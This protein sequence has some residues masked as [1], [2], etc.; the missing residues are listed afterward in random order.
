LLTLPVALGSA[1]LYFT[2]LSSVLYLLAQ[3]QW[4]PFTETYWAFFDYVSIAWSAAVVMLAVVTLTAGALA[5]RGI[6][7]VAG[8]VLLVVPAMWLPL[9]LMWMP[10]YDE[11]TAYATGT[12]HSL[13]AES[14]F[15]AQQ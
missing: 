13:A 6:L 12:F 15:Y 9:S 8:V 3:R 5:G 1:G 7:A 2:I 4:L 14:S 10:R 11:R